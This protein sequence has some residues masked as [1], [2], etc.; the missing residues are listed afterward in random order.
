M[1]LYY[2]VFALGLLVNVL[3]PSSAHGSFF[4]A[5]VTPAVNFVTP[6]A[7]ISCL[8]DQEPCFTLVEYANGV[9]Q[10]FVDY[11]AFYFIPGRHKLNFSIVIKHAQHITLRSVS[12]GK[13][14]SVV[15]LDS[16]TS[17]TWES[18]KYIKISSVVFNL[19]GNFLCSVSRCLYD[20]ILFLSLGMKTAE[21]VQL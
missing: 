7:S 17:I 10:Y 5:N 11:T 8:I 16:E 14:D 4:P 20:C 21:I 2:I 3:C 15:V 12:D 19:I 6:N 9:E 18:C 1:P 13:T